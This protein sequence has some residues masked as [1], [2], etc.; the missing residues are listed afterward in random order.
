VNQLGYVALGGAVGSGLTVVAHRWPSGASRVLAV[1]AVVCGLLGAFSAAG[2]H[3]AGLTALLGYG[4]LSTAAPLTSVLLPLPTARDAAHV[5][6]LARRAA[7]AMATNG[8]VCAAFATAG[9][10]AVAVGITIY[11]KLTWY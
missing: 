1:N 10:L 6:G 8:I 4:V 5:W 2:V 3:S 9:Y 11:R 7:V